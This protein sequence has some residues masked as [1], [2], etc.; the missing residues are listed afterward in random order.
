MGNTDIRLTLTS[1]DPEETFRIGR[2]IGETLEE[3]AI[4]ALIGELGAGKT[5]LTQ[6]IARGLGIEEGYQVT[7]PTFTLINEYPGRLHLVHLDAYRLSG[8]QDLLDMGYEEY[9]FSKSIT[10]I[11]WADRIRDVLPDTTIVLVMTYLDPER[12]HIAFS[13]NETQVMPI[14]NALKSGGF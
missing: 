7:S 14:I 3:G 13:G 1:S 6:G 4:V 2:L 5:R 8:P 10:V 11:E 12:R 9:F